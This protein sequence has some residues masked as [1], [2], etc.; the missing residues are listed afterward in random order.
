MNLKIE[1]CTY[2]AAKFA[3]ETWHYS[4]TIPAGKLVKFGVWEDGQFIGAVIYGRGASPPLYKSM[5][6]KQTEL[7][8]LVR[9]ALK[10][11]LT[12]VSRIVA[13][14]IRL[15]RKQSPGLKAIISFADSEQDHLGIIYQAGNRTYL[16][17]S[18]SDVRYKRNGQLYHPR[19]LGA[20]YG[21]RDNKFLIDK[22]Y[23]VVEVGCKYR[24]VYFLEPG[25]AKNYQAYPYPRRH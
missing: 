18:V 2:Q 13:I 1:P 14:T 5:N 8:E 3:C 24:Y 7:C 23:Q 4:K 16:G 12:P 19:S 11:H 21:R 20:K 10:S 17:E 15:L 6:L 9:V 22:G 25:L